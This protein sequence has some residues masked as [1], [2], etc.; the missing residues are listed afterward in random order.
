MRSGHVVAIGIDA[1]GVTGPSV[2]MFRALEDSDDVGDKRFQD[3]Q[4][5]IAMRGQR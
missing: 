5:N 1:S 3:W 2:E 4:F